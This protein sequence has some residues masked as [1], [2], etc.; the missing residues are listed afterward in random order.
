MPVYG[1]LHWA[2]AMVRRAGELR[3]FLALTSAGI[4]A[5]GTRTTPLFA[6]PIFVRSRVRSSPL[7]WPTPTAPRH[8]LGQPRHRASFALY[9]QQLENRRS[10]LP[11]CA[12]FAAETA[13]GDVPHHRSS[14]YPVIERERETEVGYL[15]G[16]GFG[17]CE[18]SHRGGPAATLTSDCFAGQSS[19]ASDAALE[20][21]G[22]GCAARDLQRIRACASRT[23]WVCLFPSCAA[24]WPAVFALTLLELL[25][26]P[27]RRRASSPWPGNSP[28]HGGSP[29][30]CGMISGPLSA[31]RVRPPSLARPALGRRGG[32]ACYASALDQISTV[33]FERGGFTSAGVRSQHAPRLGISA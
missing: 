2:L 31:A 14:L 30:C 25:A 18:T 3:G 27:L 24:T 20:P 15:L 13:S 10:Y 9:F 1:L 4:H 8:N 28:I 22:L 33:R 19:P 12:L 6:P 23:N 21:P 11:A 26:V 17:L 29:F 32:G 16:N 7:R 5:P